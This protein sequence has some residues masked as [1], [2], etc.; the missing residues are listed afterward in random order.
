[1]T[2]DAPTLV[3]SVPD[4]KLEKDLSGLPGIEVVRWDMGDAA[5][6][7]AFCNRQAAP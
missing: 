2:S 3:I 5:P 7:A 4:D 1:M 6:R